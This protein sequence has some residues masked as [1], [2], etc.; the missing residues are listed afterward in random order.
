MGPTR[1]LVFPFTVAL[2]GAGNMRDPAQGLYARALARAL[3]ERLDEAP[4]LS[5]D[6]ATL[7]A[8]GAPG[9]PSQAPEEHGW[10]VAT[11]PWTLGEAL[12][13]KLPEGTRLLLHGSAELTDRVR[14][15][16]LLVD[17]EKQ[18]LALDHVVL[19]PRAELFAALDEA[20]AAV[21]EVLGH[22]LPE[23]A[24]P[25]G[26]VEAFVAFLRGRDMSAALEA[27]VHVSDP[28]RA[29]DGYL[30]A[31]R[32]DPAFEE[33]QARLL[34]LA[35]DFALAGQGPR[36][37]A[38]AA[39]EKLLAQ[40][41]RAYKAL[42]ALAE[43]DLAEHRPQDAEAH[44]RALLDLR[45]DWWPAFERL[46]T[47]LTRQGKHEEA[48]AWFD[49]ALSEKSNDP[50]ALFGKALCLAEAGRLEEAVGL[51][52]RVLPQATGAAR[53]PLHKN[54]A[55]A[56]EKLGRWGEAGEHR[57]A[58]RELEGKPRF[59]VDWWRDKLRRFLPG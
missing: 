57:D 45:G 33:A 2:D 6:V 50:D 11:Q 47:A 28:E 51:W 35:L 30:E 24:W 40:D 32:R 5:T 54:L 7:T 59:G 27:G 13:V 36:S 29:F 20:A 8:H 18:A 34:S 31:L 48:L 10:V 15:R 26:E 4:N 9:A 42:A 55:H 3:A 53:L 52:R 17:Q 39:C 25:T 56:L 1:L 12:A 38:R 19:R 21:A 43:I 49:R 41:G 58:V 44:L 14:L 22:A 37:A 23:A 16:L 46:G